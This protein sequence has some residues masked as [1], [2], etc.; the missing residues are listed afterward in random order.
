MKAIILTDRGVGCIEAP[1]IRPPAIRT[2]YNRDL[3]ERYEQALEAAMKKKVLFKPE[4]QN[5]I[6][7]LMNHKV[8]LLEKGKLYPVPEGYWIELEYGDGRTFVK[9]PTYPEASP[10]VRAI[11][12][13]KQEP[14]IKSIREKFERWYDTEFKQPTQQDAI[15]LLV[16]TIE[17]LL[18]N[19]KCDCNNIPHTDDCVW[20]NA[21]SVVEIFKK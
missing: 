2:I 16:N 21:K 20:N 10:H 1:D 3:R 18:D 19:Y 12:V 13:P 14:A 17:A 6:M 15:K 4:E 11:L 9:N 5:A 8:G 7:L